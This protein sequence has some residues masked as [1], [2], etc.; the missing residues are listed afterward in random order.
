M[1][2]WIMDFYPF[3]APF[4]VVVAFVGNNQTNEERKYGHRYSA[5]SLAGQETSG[6]QE[7][8]HGGRLPLLSMADE[9]W[10]T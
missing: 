1:P 2:L 9:N 6:F 7:I 10:L 8:A 5:K 3:P 4:Q